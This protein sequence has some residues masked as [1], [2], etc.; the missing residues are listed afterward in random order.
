M[1]ALDGFAFGLFVTSA[2][3]NVS[4]A[5]QMCAP[6]VHVSIKKVPT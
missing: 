2:N 4:A 5:L 1:M 3:M 6:R